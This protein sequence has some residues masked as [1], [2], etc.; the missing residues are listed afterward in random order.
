MIPY[1]ADRHADTRVTNVTLGVWLFLASEVMLF[2]ALFSSYALLRVSAPEWPSG[3]ALLEL[4]LGALNTVVLI[5]LTSFVWRARAL[6]PAQV[7]ARLWLASGL[8]VIFLVIKA[9]EYSSEIG[10]G[11]LPSTNLFL[12]LYFT[13]TGFHA[14]HVI[15]GLVANVWAATGLR[16]VGEAMTAGRVQAL[17]MYW[18][19]VDAIWLVI[20]VLFYAS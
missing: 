14:L 7:S 8:G 6:A 16:R 11:L 10:R 20:F 13:L 19:F 3:S 17:A 12:A 15:G 1:T 5:L 2:G 18:V 9:F 4:P